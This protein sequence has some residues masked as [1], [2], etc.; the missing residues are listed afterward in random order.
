[1]T[2]DQI[3]A[4]LAAVENGAVM[5]ADI[6]AELTRL[7]NEAAGHRTKLQKIT[8]DLGL[9][10]VENIDEAVAGLK[11]SLDAITKTGGKPDEIGAKIAALTKQVETLTQTVAEKDKL[12]AAEKEKRIATIRNAKTVEALTAAKAVKPAELAKILSGN[13]QVKDDDSLV[14]LEGDKEVPLADGIANYLKANP[15]F[16]SNSANP[17]AGGGAPGPSGEKDPEKMTMAEYVEWRKAGG[18][19]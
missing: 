6:K 4:A 9:K 18:G 5:T 10:D 14:Y 16:M 19:K 17:G 8:T 2:L 15:E 13:V 1:M 7:R 3:Y 11:A 12:T